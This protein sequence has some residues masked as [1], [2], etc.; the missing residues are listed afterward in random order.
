MVILPSSGYLFAGFVEKRL[1]LC[2][3]VNSDSAA[4]GVD[5]IV[6]DEKLD[7]VFLV[8]SFESTK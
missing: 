4:S 6:F 3:H 1:L 7:F 5:F 2:T 8:V